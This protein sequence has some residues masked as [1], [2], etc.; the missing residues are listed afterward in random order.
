MPASSI[1]LAEIIAVGAELTS[2]AKLN[3]NSQWLSTELLDLGIVTGWH[4][5]ITDDLAINVAALKLAVER[6][7]LV[8]VTGGLGPT[9]DDLTREALAQLVG[10]ELVL[11]PVSLD[12]IETY[13]RKRQ[14]PM[15]ERNRIQAYF[16]RSSV[17]LINPIGTAP[18]VWLEVPRTGRG[19]CRI[20]AMPGVPSEMYK[21][22][23]EQVVP[24]LP[25]QD[26]VILKARLNTFGCGE[27]QVEEMLGDLTARNR[28]PEVG[29]TAHDAT[30]TLRIIAHGATAEECRAKIDATSLLIRERL[31]D[32]VYG[33]E[34]E[35][36][37]DV[38]ARTLASSGRTLTTIETGTTGLLTLRWIETGSDCYL[39]GEVWPASRWDHTRS[40]QEQTRD[41]AQAARE[42]A[43]ADFALA[44]SPF[45]PLPTTLNS[46]PVEVFV[47]LAT[48]E[49]IL[50]ETVLLSGNPAIHQS[51]TAKI[52][53]DLLRHFLAGR[54]SR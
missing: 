30:I 54:T 4:T 25:G 36:L 32:L 40:M 26:R 22:F 45:P 2:G 13:F 48:C 3:T 51:R 10:E 42:R 35:E 43:G 21:M 34:D 49:G 16:P 7:D 41:V 17:A 5:T 27:S 20:A 46:A 31:G 53:S 39:G 12:L 15:P 24:R 19:A 50:D 47:A 9:L 1:H 52:A 28:D 18:G 33:V 44:I 37:E 23:I 14:R 38:V 6:A 8:L 29:I 11:D